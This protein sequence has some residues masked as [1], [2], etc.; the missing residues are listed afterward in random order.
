MKFKLK[1]KVCGQEL[2]E[3]VNLLKH[4]VTHPAVLYFD[5]IPQ[6]AWA[7]IP[8]APAVSQPAQ[9]DIEEAEEELPD[10]EGVE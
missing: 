9:I 2:D 1:C 3:G 8:R 10:E 4:I 5:T 7:N 6:V